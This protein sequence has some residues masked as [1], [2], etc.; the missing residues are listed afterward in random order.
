MPDKKP[1]YQTLPG[2]IIDAK[3]KY[4]TLPGITV[5]AKTKK[6]ASS[7]T[8]W[9]MTPPRN[10]SE[11]TSPAS[12]RLKQNIELEND[13]NR[14][15]RQ[16]R[17]GL[18]EISREDVKNV[19]EPID[20]RP[21]DSEG[22]A[23]ERAAAADEV[24]KK[25]SA[26]G[27]FVPYPL[28]K[29]PSMAVNAA[30]G[31]GDAYSNYNEGDYLNAAINTAGAFP[32]GLF[33][34]YGTAAEV[35]G[36]AAEF[37]DNF[38]L[39]QKKNGGWLDKYGEEINANEG[40]SSAP[41]EWMGEGYSNVGRNYSPAWGGQFEDGG[42]IPQAQKGKKVIVDGKEYDTSSEE[43]KDLYRWGPNDDG[44]GGIGYFDKDGVLVT[45][46][47]T[48]PEVVVF[49]KDKDTKKFYDDLGDSDQYAFEQMVKK[50]GPVNITK[51]KGKGIFSGTAGH[52]NPFTDQI[53]IDPN[54]KF[55]S[56]DN[57][58]YL[59]ELAHKVQFDRQGKFDVMGN[60]VFNDLPDY[61]T[62]NSP[63]ED[64]STTE[65]QAHS[66]I[67]PT[68]KDE[69]FNYSSDDMMGY[70]YNKFNM[71]G[72]LPGS[73]GFTY[74]R[75]NS[76]APSNGPYAKKTKAS[77]QNGETIHPI[78]LRLPK[79]EKPKPFF[80]GYGFSQ[81]PVNNVNVYGVGA[82]GTGNISDRLNLSGNVNSASVF[83][84]GGQKMFMDPRFEVGMK[85]KFNNGGSMSYYQNG[86][87]WK[88]KSISKNGGWLENYAE[89]GQ[90]EKICYDENGYRIPCVDEAVPIEYTFDKNDPNLKKH[91]E[92]KKA[93]KSYIDLLN[94]WKRKGVMSEKEYES[95]L[96]KH[97]PN[98]MDVE[99]YVVDLPSSE[100]Q[101]QSFGFVNEKDGIREI[102]DNYDFPV[103]KEYRFIDP[104]NMY[105]VFGPSQSVIGFANSKRE[106]YPVKGTG[107]STKKEDLEFLKDQKG[108]YNYLQQKGFNQPTIM[109]KHGGNIP[110]AQEGITYTHEPG[111][112]GAYRLQ[113]TVSPYLSNRD[114]KQFT[115]APTDPRQVNFLQ[116]Y[117]GAIS[118]YQDDPD[119][120]Y[121]TQ[122]PYEGAKH[123][124]IDRFIIDP[125]FSNRNITNNE[126]LEQNRANVL[127][128]MYKY[129]M[130]QDP[131]HKGKAFRKAKRF[132]RREIDPKIKGPFLQ[133]Y[134]TV[135]TENPDYFQ[136]GYQGPENFTNQNNLKDLYTRELIDETGQKKVTQ[137][138]I[139]K[140]KDVS[141]DY[142]KNYKGM[143]KKQA[144]EQWKKWEE[145]A[146]ADRGNYNY[147]KANG[148]PAQNT[149]VGW[150]IEYFD[151]TTKKTATKHFDNN[152]EAEEFYNATPGE[153]TKYSDV[154]SYEKKKF[155]G[156]VPKA[157]TG[158]E[159]AEKVRC[160]DNQVYLEGTGCIDIRSRLYKELYESG[161]L[162]QQGPDESVIFPTSKPLVINSKLTEDQKR[163]LLRKDM[164]ETSLSNQNQ[165][166]IKQG[167]DQSNISKI[168]D[169]ATHPGTAIRAYNKTGYVPSNLSAAADDMGGSSSIINTLSPATWLKG[170]GNAVNQFVSDPFQTTKD[171]VQG[172]GNL[173]GYAANSANRATLL[174]GQSMSKYK[175][176]FGDAGTNERALK[177]VGNVADALPLLE[178]ANLPGVRRF[179]KPSA[180]TDLG[181][182]IIESKTFSRYNPTTGVDEFY[183][184]NVADRLVPTRSF[185]DVAHKM[186]NLKDDLGITPLQDFF[187]K[188]IPKLAP[189]HSLEQGK[190]ILFDPETGKL[191]DSNTRYWLNR[192]YGHTPSINSLLGPRGLKPISSSIGATPK[193]S[194]L[195]GNSEMFTNPRQYFTKP[196]GGPTYTPNY[197]NISK[198]ISQGSDPLAETLSFGSY[199]PAPRVLD[200]RKI[201][202]TAAGVGIGSGL[203]SGAL[204]QKKEGGVVKDDNGYWNPDNRGKVV[205]IDSPII[206]MEGVDQDLIG[207][208]D[209][210]DVQYM[211]PGKNYKFKGKKVR[212][213]P[214]GKNGVNQQDEKVAQQLDQLTNFT[215]YNKPTKGGWLDKY[216]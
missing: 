209:E 17:D 142:F 190:G 116:N 144:K 63:Y 62:G 124:N 111:Q 54:Q 28:I 43:Y 196:S 22:R 182:A 16:N 193:Q 203:V 18:R 81:N 117:A 151:P 109:Q 87:D 129:Y 147:Q 104:S 146:N 123:W 185:E 61:M 188:R 141:F 206:T 152:E 80:K 122:V 12:T 165:A 160:G 76:P 9:K 89:G 84:P 137:E 114:I 56:R 171:I 35:A 71:G 153:K 150:N 168:L 189:E 15:K 125:Q 187:Y 52:Y 212:E 172:T 207:I 86:L 145:E 194:S 101:Q 178:F 79:Y 139:D 2:V 126:S 20:T 214:V 7:T 156:G 163:A 112:R 57:D 44:K 5:N 179:I 199:T 130:L 181:E 27:Q 93:E 148:R 77:A 115:E 180:P 82:Y 66:I 106:F 92:I 200:W 149:Q 136:Q 48:L 23:R 158:E 31:I 143:S 85:Y 64:S 8:D 140:L 192:Q 69:F 26:I 138:E 107:Y 213:Y 132:V 36:A 103:E 108:L 53:T 38:G 162:V 184:A 99:K 42:Y 95:I 68:L 216:N 118:G 98:L 131:E 157:Q 41:K 88:P 94:E 210:G 167:Y 73:V 90:A 39:E 135:G 155:G 176:P 47:T 121:P 13:V 70:N 29:Y 164:L 208:S 65:Y 40:S 50:Y 91:A 83:Y 183:N 127:S 51:N 67:E 6:K 134:N 60:W 34:K 46:K 37:T 11:S 74:A 186:G 10:V 78:N 154:S 30:Y 45:G 170:A 119:F 19:P 174:P 24:L 110:D 4:K 97:I 215:N 100:D 113:R 173:L 166:Q 195:F 72:S 198:T 177:F 1:K 105:S 159:V 58:T 120:V 96:L 32:F 49:P 102:T 201:G 175:S 191:F 161:K 128:D 211:T 205:E 202:Q 55:L 3:R 33:G 75:T 169:I 197:E 204:K 25:S 59:A 133:S 14:Y 21:W